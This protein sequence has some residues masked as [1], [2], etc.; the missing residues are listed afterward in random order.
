MQTREKS[1]AKM[2]NT[3]FAYQFTWG[4]KFEGKCGIY[5]LCIF[6]CDTNPFDIFWLFHK[7]FFQF[8]FVKDSCRG[9]IQKGTCFFRYRTVKH[10]I[11][12]GNSYFT[13]LFV[14]NDLTYPKVSITCNGFH[15]S[16]VLPILHMSLCNTTRAGVSVSIGNS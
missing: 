2:I 7:D 1:I 4:C 6:W 13:S 5:H 14:D 9:P 8:F 12:R 11:K 3:A 10:S 16:R 15:L